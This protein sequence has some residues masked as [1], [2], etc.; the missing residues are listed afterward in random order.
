M[1]AAQE[2][3]IT[4]ENQLTMT[5]GLDYTVNDFFCTDPD[6]LDYLNDPGTVWYYYNAPYTLLDEVIANATNTDFNAYFSEKIKDPIGMQGTF[7]K[8]GYNNI[9][10]STARSMARFGIL[11]LNKGSWN[12]V[13]ILNDSS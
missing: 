11:N 10:F 9:Y 5:T 13:P 4:I 7:I 8:V 1:S 3:A 2:G 12:G 6:C